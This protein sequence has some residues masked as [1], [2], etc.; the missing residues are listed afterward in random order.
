MVAN[1]PVA[2]AIAAAKARKIDRSDF[3]PIKAKAALQLEGRFCYAV[4][5]QKREFIVHP[6]NL[7]KHNY[8][9]KFEM[10]WLIAAHIFVM[11][12]EKEWLHGV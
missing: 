4:A 11:I 3:F 9:L 5:D 8:K 1:V 2:A 7:S 10:L 6:T 12:S